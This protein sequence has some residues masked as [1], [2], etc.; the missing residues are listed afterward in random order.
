MGKNRGLG[1]CGSSGN[2]QRVAVGIVALDDLGQFRLVGRFEILRIP[3]DLFTTPDGQVAQ[4]DCL[5]Q[6]AGI[7]R[8]IRER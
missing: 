3:L 2:L 7:V 6:R 8:E 4:E 5:G 1:I